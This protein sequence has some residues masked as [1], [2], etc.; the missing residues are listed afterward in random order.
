VLRKATLQALPT[1]FGQSQKANSAKFAKDGTIGSMRIVSLNV[2]LPYA[3]RYEGREVITGG[4][5]K[6]VSRAVLRFGNFDGDRQADLAN[7]GGL[8]RQCASTPST[9]TRTGADS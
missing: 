6:P 4:A 8:K 1:L 7:H 9:T 5:K 2:V 3:Q